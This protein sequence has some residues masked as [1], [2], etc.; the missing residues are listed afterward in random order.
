MTL[1]RTTEEFFHGYEK[2]AVAEALTHTN[3]EYTAWL[4]GCFADYYV[5]PSIKSHLA[6]LNVVVD[7]ANNAAA[8]PVSGDVPVSF[9]HSFD[10]A[11]FVAASLTLPKWEPKTYL[12]GEKLTWHQLVELAQDIKGTKFE[13]TYDSE[14]DLKSGKVTELPSHPA[15]YPSFPKQDVQALLATVGRMAS[16]GIFDIKA[17]HPIVQDFP[18]LHLRTM[19]ELLVEAWG[20]GKR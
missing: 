15:L 7:V 5:V 20:K 13:V 11:R 12:V 4:I 10:V 8:I 19:K 9:T 1:I 16:L 17:G 6:I 3:L 18:D 14:D 2:L